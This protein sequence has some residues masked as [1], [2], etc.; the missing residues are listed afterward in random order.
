MPV[1]TNMF[2]YHCK[3]PAFIIHPMGTR[4]R[5]LSYVF[6]KTLNAFVLTQPRGLVEEIKKH[7]ESPSK[8]FAQSGPLR[9][10]LWASS[11]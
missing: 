9:T 11:A 10:N 2:R 5:R 1:A 7:R 8:T 6:L 3:R 4:K